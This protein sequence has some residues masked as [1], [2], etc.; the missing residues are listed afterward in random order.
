MI[1]VL[2]AA[3]PRLARTLPVG[4][5]I[6]TASE[7]VPVHERFQPVHSVPAAL[8]PIRVNPPGRLAQQTAGR[9]WHPRPGQD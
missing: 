4:G 9:V 8:T 3:S 1:P 7:P 6:A 5:A 2:A